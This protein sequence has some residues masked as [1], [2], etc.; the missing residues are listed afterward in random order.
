MVF[1]IPWCVFDKIQL[2]VWINLVHIYE[3]SF[4]TQYNSMFKFLNYYI[5][6]SSNVYRKIWDIDSNLKTYLN[7]MFE[8][9][10]YSVSV[11]D[12]R[13]EK[14]VLAIFH[15]KVFNLLMNLKRQLVDVYELWNHRMALNFIF[16]M[17]QANFYIKL[18]QVTV[19]F[20]LQ[21]KTCIWQCLIIFILVIKAIHNQ[22]LNWMI[23]LFV[24][25]LR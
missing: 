25:L 13:A 5:K 17:K 12:Q 3:V 23:K 1:Q 20:N 16:Q 6:I 15:K 18:F 14:I 4:M 10:Q 9:F 19:T 2:A 22:F 7:K 21:P 11:E 24:K 8:K